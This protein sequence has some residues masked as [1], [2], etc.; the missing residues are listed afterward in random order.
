MWLQLPSIDE[1]EAQVLGRKL[2]IP[3]YLVDRTRVDLPFE[4]GTTVA[5]CIPQIGHLINLDNYASFGLFESRQAGSLAAR[6]LLNS[7]WTYAWYLSTSTRSNPHL[8]PQDILCLPVQGLNLRGEVAWLGLQVTS[9]VNRVN[10][11]PEDE[12]MPVDREAYLADVLYQMQHHKAQGVRMDLLFKKQIFAADD[13]HIQEPRF[14][15]L[16]FFQVTSFTS[17]FVNYHFLAGSCINKSA[18]L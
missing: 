13:A 16:C 17:Y 4:I 6:P 8:V 2:T 15:E 10:A 1:L 11:P 5:S 7:A 18:Q 14:H 12:H 3:V 9:W